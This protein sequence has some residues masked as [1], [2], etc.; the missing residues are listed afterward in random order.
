MSD[1]RKDLLYTKDHEWVK[2]GVGPRTVRVGITDFAQAALGDVTYIQLPDMGK[3][4]KTHEVFGSVESV[5]AVSEL[6]MPVAGKVVKRNEALLN[7]P[8]PINTSPFDD[9]WMIDIE[10]ESEDE[11][12]KLLSSEAY[13]QHAQ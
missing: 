7:D 11:V 2:V 13:A 4:F 6:F 10:L 9:A 8:A 5:K 3:S 1:I 12:K